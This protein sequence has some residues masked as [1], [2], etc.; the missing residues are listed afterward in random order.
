[1]AVLLNIFSLQGNGEMDNQLTLWGCI[2]R[3]FRCM[4]NPLIF[5]IPMDQRFFTLLAIAKCRKTSQYAQ[6]GSKRTFPSL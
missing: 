5:V 2:L 3:P 4:L 6:S 1:M